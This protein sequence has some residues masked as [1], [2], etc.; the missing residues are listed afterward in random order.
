MRANPY[1]TPPTS[2]TGGGVAANVTA[3]APAIVPGPRIVVQPAAGLV[4]SNSAT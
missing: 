1:V 4:G 3:L 2:V